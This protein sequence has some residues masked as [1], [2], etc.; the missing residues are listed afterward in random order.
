ALVLVDDLGDGQFGRYFPRI[1]PERSPCKPF[2]VLLSAQ[3]HIR[4]TDSLALLRRV[5]VRWNPARRAGFVCRAIGSVGDLSGEQRQVHSDARAATRALSRQV[6]GLTGQEACARRGL[7]GVT[8]HRPDLSR[9][10][11]ILSGWIDRSVA[12]ARTN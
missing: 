1:L 11:G 10:L 5:D 3:L 2:L 6:V 4:H 12:L 8:H 9:L 7:L